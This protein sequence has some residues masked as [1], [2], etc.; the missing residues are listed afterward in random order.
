MI[1]VL[2]TLVVCTIFLDDGNLMEEKEEEE[3]G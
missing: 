3:H 2:Q 1:I